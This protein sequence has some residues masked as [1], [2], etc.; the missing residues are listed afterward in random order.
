[1]IRKQEADRAYTLYRAESILAKQFKI[2]A[3][4]VELYA[5]AAS[6]DLS[7]DTG[8]GKAADVK[9]AVAARKE[10]YNELITNTVGSKNLGATMSILAAD[11]SLA[12]ETADKLTD[13]QKA[14]V[15]AF[16]EVSDFSS[17]FD[18]EL[19]AKTTIIDN[20][21]HKAATAAATT[22]LAWQQAGEGAKLTLGEYADALERS[23]L[24]T[25]VWKDDLVK[26]GLI[27]KYTDPLSAGD[28]VRQLAG[29]GSKGV[30][31]VHQMANGSA[32]EVHRMASDLVTNTKEGG[33]GA[34]LQ[35]DAAMQIMA[36]NGKSGAKNVVDEIVTQLG[37]GTQ[38]IK[39]IAN[40]YAGALR[41]ALNPIITALGGKPIGPGSTNIAGVEVP[42]T[43]LNAIDNIPPGPS[44]GG[45]HPVYTRADGGPFLPPQATFMPPQ[46]SHGMVQWAE[47]ETQGEWFL[48]RAKS[49]RPR[50]ERILA[51]I[52]ADF[53]FGIKKYA[54]GGFLSQYGDVFSKVPQVPKTPKGAF[55]YSASLAMTK[56]RNQAL[57]YLAPMVTAA[58]SFG[59]APAPAGQAMQAAQAMLARFGWSA[60]WP[61][62]YHLEM[63]EAGFNNLAQNPTSTAFGVGQF[64]DSTW[65]S[66]GGHKTSNLLDQL[67][68]MGRYIAQRYGD[69][70]HAWQYHLAHHSYAD[71]GYHMPVFDSGGTLAPGVNTV[72]NATGAPEHLVPVRSGGGSVAIDA[73]LDL[74]G[75]KITGVDDLEGVLAA[76]QTK[77]IRAIEDHLRRD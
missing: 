16:A 9:A 7:P 39:D 22:K 66:V 28:V 27:L 18:Q 13:S 50:S 17:A 70:N 77:V 64:L 43:L 12:S 20:F 25:Q 47:P 59:G 68:Y 2:S 44:P 30:D 54:D 24:K 65:A 61:A 48:P 42:N 23:N 4:A 63:S 8:Q 62:F 60:Q 55:G 32:T 53:G 21:G 15:S 41:G 49:K 46:G 14:L 57:A 72:Y 34:A 69:P 11:Q 45:G 73:R 5:Q 38:Q 19:Q 31:L 75:A 10:L 51:D 29:M 74:R 33:Q 36:A 52:A 67:E 6:I 1:M 71:G 3:L 40:D 56:A 37:L 58:A 26:V 76:H 35:M